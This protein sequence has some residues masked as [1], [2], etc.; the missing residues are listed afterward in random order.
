MEH[1]FFE[2]GIAYIS[3]IML[4][5]P[6]IALLLRNALVYSRSSSIFCA[7]GI[8]LGIAIQSGLVLLG[9]TFIN[10]EGLFF[11]VLRIICPLFLIYLGIASGYSFLKDMGK[12]EK[13]ITSEVQD[14]GK[15]VGFFE[16]LLIE[17]FNPLALTFFVSISTG[18]VKLSSQSYI[19]LG[20]WLE[21]IILGSIWFCGVAYL[22]STPQFVN[23]IKRFSYLLSGLASLIFL[24][25]GTKMLFIAII[26]KSVH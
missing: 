21:M 11:K 17:I 6:S 10:H 7:L 13:L 24:F 12:K 14:S 18:I 9:F 22:S 16:G 15:Y 19:K 4:P 25:I 20:Y 8:M 26:T 23:K 2:L 5:G 3:G 1:H